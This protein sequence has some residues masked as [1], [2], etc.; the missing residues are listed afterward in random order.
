MRNAL[1]Q[2][3]KAIFYTA[4]SGQYSYLL[5]SRRNSLLVQLSGA[6]CVHMPYTLHVI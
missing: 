3:W 5:P 4:H 1:G 6:Y 2:E